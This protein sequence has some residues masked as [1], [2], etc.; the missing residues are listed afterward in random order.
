MSNKQ[1][2]ALAGVI[3]VIII[4]LVI[5]VIFLNSANRQYKKDNQ[6]LVEQVKD[7]Q[8]L[9]SLKQIQYQIEAVKGNL[10]TQTEVIRTKIAVNKE[11][12]SKEVKRIAEQPN[13]GDRKILD[14]FFKR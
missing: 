6:Q 3:A 12:Q 7:L 4:S 14:K 11:N 1:K 8:K 9:D 13:S 2:Y 5:A 10:H